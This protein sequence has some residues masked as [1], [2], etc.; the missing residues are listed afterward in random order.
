MNDLNAD[1][2]TDLDP[3]VEALVTEVIGQVAD[4]WT[5]IVLEVLIEH[6]ELRFSKLMKLTDGV[7]QKMLTQTLRR[8]EREGLVV[9]TIHPVIPPKVEYRLT[10]L[11]AQLSEAFCGV[12]VWAAQNVDRIEAARRAFD[13][14]ST[15]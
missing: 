2:P 9:R 7:S 8:M 12:W 1:F 10:D 14:R 6:G 4:K 13:A 3:R 15:D 11:G 5:M